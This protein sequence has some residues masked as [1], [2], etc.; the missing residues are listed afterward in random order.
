MPNHHHMHC[1]CVSTQMHKL[2]KYRSLRAHYG[3]SAHPQFCFNFLLRS[4]TYLVQAWACGETGLH[5]LQ[6]AKYAA[7]QWFMT[8]CLL[9][10]ARFFRFSEVA[11]LRECDISFYYE[12]ME[13]FIESS[14]TD[15]FREGAWV[16]IARTNSNICPVA[17]LEQYFRLTDI[18]GNA[19]KLLFGGNEK[20]ILPSRLRRDKLYPS[21]GKKLQEIDLDPKLFSLHSLRAGGA[22]AAANA[23]IPDCWFKRHSRWLRRM[24]RMARS[25]IG[26]K[27]DSA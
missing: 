4:N 6:G 24:Q 3:L 19:D 20:R 21:A 16:P 27:T 25:K 17:M 1:T 15:Q 18:Q 2:C 22:S 26:L 8:I 14:K 12:H 13:V 7:V 23:G 9:G 11:S 10:Y 5:T